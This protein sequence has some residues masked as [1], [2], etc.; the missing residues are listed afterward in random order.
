MKVLKK[1]ISDQENI[2]SLSEILCDRR[3]SQTRFRFRISK[4]T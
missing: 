4:S 2:S 3:F 1:L